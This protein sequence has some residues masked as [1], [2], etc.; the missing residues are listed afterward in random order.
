MSY[1]VVESFGHGLDARKHILNL[2]PGALYR[3]KNCNL[4]RGGEPEAAKAFV[5]K[6]T[7]PINTFGLLAAG[8][9]L[10]VFGGNGYTSADMPAGI[11]YQQLVHPAGGYMTAV[12]HATVVKGKP[13]VIASY[14]VGYGVFFNGLFI[15][16][17]KPPGGALLTKQVGGVPTPYSSLADIAVNFAGQI[18]ASGIYTAVAAGNVVTL[19]GRPSLPVSCSAI[20]LSGRG[21]NDQSATAALVQAAAS[22]VSGATAT[23][24]ITVSGV[25]GSF[26]SD[27]G[28]Y[29]DE[30]VINGVNINGT[31]TM[32]APVYASSDAAAAAIITGRINLLTSSP[33]YTATISSADPNTVIIS[34]AAD[35][36]AGANG[37][38]VSLISAPKC[39][40]SGV[41]AGGTSLATGL[42]QIS[43]VTFGGTFETDD[44]W[45]ITLAGVVYTMASYVPPGGG[46]TGDGGGGGGGG[47]GGDAAP[48][49]ANGQRPIMAL[50]KNSKTYAIAGPNLFGSKIG[51]CTKWNTGTGV[52][53]TDM[54]SE[55]A[56]AEI[57]TALA[58]FQGNLAIF[59]RTTIQIY[60]VDPDP[61]NNSQ[62]QAM[63][64]IGTMAGKTVTPFGDTDVFFLADTG[65]RSLKTRT[66]TNSATMT[67]IGSPVDPLV[68]A[69]I[70]AAGADISKAVAVMEPVDGRFL[71][72]IG[73]T[74]Y[75]F[76]YFPD[77]KVGGW[78]TYESGLAITDFAVIDQKLFARA[79][80]NVYLLGGD[81]NDQYSQQVVDI[82]LPFLSSRQIGT[83]KHYEALDVA[84]DGVFDVLVATDPTQPD[85]EETIATINGSTIGLGISPF[86]AEDGPIISLRFVGR[87]GKYSRLSN[88]AVH[89]Q[90]LKENA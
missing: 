52:F 7:L 60:F 45:A 13:F 62:L 2:P 71:L 27:T 19:T 14:N 53:I 31:E 39:T 12:V 1:F 22:A 10:F 48:G 41:M 77:A 74:T 50:T 79:G 21:V 17:W 65:L 68:V 36:G 18:N 59:S 24:T 4:N 67:D 5:F 11:Q 46:D 35:A 38:V 33:D 85:A 42:S 75:V 28:F 87:P 88:I 89:F 81:N 69:A 58:L 43:S 30:L 34:A 82:K 73:T 63:Q 80:D 86:S 51:D 8:G 57:L 6:G 66:G 56:G 15:Q 40:T 55:L 23:A 37:F 54:S 84:C 47:S 16:D 26:N 70:R 76:N 9:K 49:S 64:N 32:S 83:L 61:S 29:E 3:A 20:G 44:S 25:S 78:T 72:Q 90:P